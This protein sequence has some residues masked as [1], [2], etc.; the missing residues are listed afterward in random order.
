M[1]VCSVS[2]DLS[3][4]VASSFPK[5][6]DEALRQKPVPVVETV[7]AAAPAVGHLG[8]TSPG[9]RALDRQDLEERHDTLFHRRFFARGD[10]ISPA[11]ACCVSVA[12][13]TQPLRV[14]ADAVRP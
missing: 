6:V 10:E 2:N 13:P 1:R 8:K 12:Y 14:F 3:A 5:E 9:P 4:A 11:V 7:L